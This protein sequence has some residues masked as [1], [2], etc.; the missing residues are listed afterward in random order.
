MSVRFRSEAVREEVFPARTCLK[1]YNRQ[2]QDN[3]IYVNE[4]LTAK[5]A[6]LAYAQHTKIY[7][8]RYIFNTFD[9]QH[10]NMLLI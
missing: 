9:I 10:V 2:C 6:M 5:R 1:D 3:Q 7:V 4:D 8:L